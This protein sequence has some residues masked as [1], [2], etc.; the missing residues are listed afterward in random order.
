MLRFVLLR[1]ALLCLALFSFALLSSVL[2]SFA[3][4]CFALL[5]LAYSFALLNL[6]CLRG[7]H[8]GEPE[9]L[10]SIAPCFETQSKTLLSKQSLVRE[11]RGRLGAAWAA[12]PPP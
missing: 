6:A 2:L 12:G 4:F 3:M 5:C 8:L 11:F 1:L 9:I 7:R 10:G